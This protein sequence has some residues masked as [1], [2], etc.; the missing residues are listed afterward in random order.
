[1]T[2]NI[3]ELKVDSFETAPAGGD[4]LL[5][6]VTAA[7]CVIIS[8]NHTECP[9]ANTCYTCAVGCQTGGGYAC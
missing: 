7:G 9:K 6:A 8:A 3:D 2:L 1:M 4:E 5:V